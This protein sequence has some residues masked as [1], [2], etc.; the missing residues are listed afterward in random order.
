MTAWKTMADPP[1]DRQRCIVWRRYEDDPFI[2]EFVV[3]TGKKYAI[4]YAAVE[5][6]NE[7]VFISGKL[8]V[9]DSDL[10]MP[11]PETPFKE[12]L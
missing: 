8:T 1:S 2:A 11:C 10:W 12:T 6:L 3:I 5:H 7:D 4:W 9:N